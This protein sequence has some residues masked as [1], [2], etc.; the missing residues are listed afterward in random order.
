MRWLVCLGVLLVGCADTGHREMSVRTSI[1]TIH[2]AQAE[3]YSSFGHF[4][5]SMR[6][7]GPGELGPGELATGEKDGYRFTLTFTPGGY[8]ISA[9]PD[10]YGVSGTKSYFSDQSGRIHVHTGPGT[11][12][13]NDPLQGGTPPEQSDPVAPPRD[14]TNS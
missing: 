14:K 7:L 3:Y 13:V 6:D 2:M 12:T 11:A 1:V 4:A 8:A 10:Q 5:A 9:V